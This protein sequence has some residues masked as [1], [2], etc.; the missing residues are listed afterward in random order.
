MTVGEAS[1]GGKQECKEEK[2]CVAATDADCCCCCADQP[3]RVPPCLWQEV[4]WCA[5]VRSCLAITQ[6][7]ENGR[8]KRVTSVQALQMPFTR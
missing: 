7:G 5:C 2:L 1:E 4:D 6:E 3:R 8:G